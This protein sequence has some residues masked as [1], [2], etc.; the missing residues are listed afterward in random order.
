MYKIYEIL[1]MCN[2]DMYFDKS[3]F[4]DIYSKTWSL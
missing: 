1:L 4:V 3:I 2:K